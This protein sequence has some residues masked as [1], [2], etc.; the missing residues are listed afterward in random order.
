[1]PCRTVALDG[2][3]EE[4][5]VGNASGIHGHGDHGLVEH[6]Q[7][8]GGEALPWERARCREDGQV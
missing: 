5:M 8:T 1:M 4:G 7:P 2:I 6:A 3:G